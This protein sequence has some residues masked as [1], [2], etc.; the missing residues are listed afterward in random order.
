MLHI[1]E[2]GI[3]IY[4]GLSMI[5]TNLVV[6]PT[7]KQKISNVSNL[8]KL[9]IAIPLFNV[10]YALILILISTYKKGI[11]KTRHRKQ[12]KRVYSCFY[13][14]YQKRKSIFANKLNVFLFVSWYLFFVFDFF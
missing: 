7:I 12:P 2:I 9:L 14:F 13:F 8:N 10:L 6:D 1:F 5:L 11:R 3:S 4:L